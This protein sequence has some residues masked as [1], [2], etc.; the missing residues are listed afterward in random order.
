MADIRAQ[1]SSELERIIKSSYPPS[2]SVSTS[3]QAQHLV[4]L[5]GCTTQHTTCCICKPLLLTRELKALGRLAC[6][7]RRPD[8][9][10]LYPRSVL[11]RSQPTCSNC[12]RSVATVGVYITCSTGP[13]YVAQH[14]NRLSIAD[15]ASVA[16]SPRFVDTLLR[17]NPGL[18]NTLIAKANSSPREYDE[19]STNEL[20]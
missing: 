13:V 20:L 15:V 16:Q 1:L 7:C 19:V 10:S 9:P 3:P 6:T 11:V 18:L 17:Q 2:L 5:E 8:Y 14:G 4:Q 12:L